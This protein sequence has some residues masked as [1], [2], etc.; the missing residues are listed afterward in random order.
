MS[1]SCAGHWYRRKKA[2]YSQEE[3]R[4]MEKNPFTERKKVVKKSEQNKFSTK[5][6]ITSSRRLKTKNAKTINI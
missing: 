3:T 1:K 4:L 5:N 6:T 2:P